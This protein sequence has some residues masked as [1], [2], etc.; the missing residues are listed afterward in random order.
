MKANLCRDAR[1][2]VNTTLR[3]SAVLL[4]CCSAVTTPAQPTDATELLAALNDP[5]FETREAATQRLLADESLTEADILGLLGEAK[6]PEQ[7]HRLMRVARHHVLTRARIEH[8]KDDANASLGI[9]QE[10]VVAGREQ[11]AV[12]V[13]L[14]LPGFPAHA[15][16][17][18]GDLITAIDGDT[19]PAAF[20]GQGFAAK[21]RSYKPGQAMTL[22][23]RR[24]D[25][26]L[27]VKVALASGEALEAMYDTGSV[28][29]T[30][31][32]AAIWRQARGRFAQ[33]MPELEELAPVKDA[34]TGDAE[35][36]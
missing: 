32:F 7:R 24:D 5:S 35:G 23:I 17:R 19:F 15:H 10:V 13:I 14:T 2:R 3:F 20:N 1:R 29:L 34:D 36:E 9:S 4:F 22:T 16:L 6:S 11:A 31:Q 18:P 26:R 25:Q 8:F 28:G 33:A 21:V 30:F 12:R 27:D